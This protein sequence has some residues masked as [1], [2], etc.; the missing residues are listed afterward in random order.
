MTF[1]KFQ[2]K[3][4][5]KQLILLMETALGRM[6]LLQHLMRQPDSQVSLTHN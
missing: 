5:L 2:M 4:V 1:P 3:Q 6:T